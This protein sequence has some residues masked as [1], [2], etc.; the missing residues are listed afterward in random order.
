MPNEVSSSRSVFK[1]RFHALREE[2]GM[3]Q[4]AFSKY[5]GIS[6]PTVGFY[7]NAD[8]ENGRIP[9][10]DTLRL[11]CKKCNVSAD[12]LLGLSDVKNPETT[13]QAICAATGLS[14]T[15]VWYMQTL[16]VQRDLP[17]KSGRLGVLSDLLEQTQFD[18][19]LALWEQYVNLMRMEPSLS[20][21]MSP[22]YKEHSD[23]LKKHGYVVSAPDRQAQAL[24]SEQITNILRS[25]LDNLANGEEEK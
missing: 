22:D 5:L 17:P 15:A 12:Y 2:C 13:V 16:R 7:E 11:I 4:D 6:R 9:D 20:Y 21:S 8:Q 3:S 14:E 10:A 23:E 19:L 18:Y 1:E 25:L 24:F